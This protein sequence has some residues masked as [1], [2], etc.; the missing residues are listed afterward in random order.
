MIKILFQLFLGLFYFKIFL[1]VGIR[2]KTLDV[3]RMIARFYFLT[4]PRC[5]AT[6]GYFNIFSESLSIQSTQ[7]HFGNGNKAHKSGVCQCAK[8]Q[9]DTCHCSQSEEVVAWFFIH[10][11]KGLAT[12]NECLTWFRAFGIFALSSP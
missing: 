12:L 1:T 8:K 5:E 2:M 3:G 10:D 7:I 4:Q 6:R 11:R 9:F